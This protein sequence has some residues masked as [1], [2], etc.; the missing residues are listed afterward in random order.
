MKK[1]LIIILFLTV[2][3]FNG[4]VYADKMEFSQ[5]EHTVYVGSVTKLETVYT[6]DDS[7][8]NSFSWKSSDESIAV[9]QF[10]A[11][12][13]LKTGTVTIS[14]HNQ[15]GT[16]ISQTKVTVIEEGQEIEKQDP[17]EDTQEELEIKIEDYNL[18]FDKNKHEYNLMIGSEKRLNINIT[19]KTKKYSI[20]GNK[21]L[22]NGSVITIT[23]SGIRKPYIINIQKKE[24]YAIYFI[25]AISI[26]LFLNIIRLLIKNRK[27]K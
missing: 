1:K 4:Y 21:N 12:K 26:L 7:G 10:G 24:S 3:I 22:E 25:V 18:K 11:I 17:I 23:I 14:I 9:I 16:V 15:E 5:K 27:N 13:A 20:S 19:P 2:V 8:S 6:Q